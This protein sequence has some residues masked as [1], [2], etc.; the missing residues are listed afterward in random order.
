MIVV[1]LVAVLIVVVS[2][3]SASLEAPNLVHRFLKWV[4]MGV[5]KSPP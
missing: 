4:H 5:S 3:M 1:I 2:V